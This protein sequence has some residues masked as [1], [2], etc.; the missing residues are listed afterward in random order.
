[1]LLAGTAGGQIKTGMH[2]TFASGTPINSLML[3]VLQLL[4]IPGVT[5]FG[6][7]GNQPLQLA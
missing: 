4:K 7:D 2:Q 5:K 3:S 1:M 6:V